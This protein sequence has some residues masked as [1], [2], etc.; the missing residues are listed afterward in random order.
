M[1]STCLISA[2]FLDSDPG[3]PYN[4]GVGARVSVE[5]PDEARVEST[6]R[7]ERMSCRRLS[8]H[9]TTLLGEQVP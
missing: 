4:V 2:F 7:K 9:G 1:L 3:T 5:R 6:Q 8:S